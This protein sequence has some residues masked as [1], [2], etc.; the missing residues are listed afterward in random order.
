MHRP[1]DC[2]VALALIL[3]IGGAT[4]LA[5][6][7]KSTAPLSQAHAHNDYHHDRPLLDALDHGFTSVE[8]DIFLVEGRLLVGHDKSEL[9]PDRTLESLYLDPLRERVKHN[10]GR[11]FTQ[12]KAFHLLIDIK[13]DAEPTYDV[14]TNVLARYP[15]MISVVRDGKLEAKAVNVTI[16]GNRPTAI[17]EAQ[18]IRHAGVDGRL[19]DLDSDVPSHLMPLISDNWFQHFEWNGRGTIGEAD[20]EKLEEVVQKAHAQDRKIRFW[21][22]PDT[23][24]MWSVLHVSGVDMINTDDLACE[25]HDCG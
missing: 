12:G 21:A 20:Q 11:V 9:K 16:S 25:R 5:D 18:S 13:S 17:M 15:E 14:L 7:T 1:Q 19:S 8:A 2:I 23:M 10:R 24:A 3:S 4:L 6:E 22:T